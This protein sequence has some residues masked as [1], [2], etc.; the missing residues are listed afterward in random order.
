VGVIGT[1]C[2]VVNLTDVGALGIEGGIGLR[3]SASKD[4]MRLEVGLFF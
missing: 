4:E 3:G 1:S 2:G